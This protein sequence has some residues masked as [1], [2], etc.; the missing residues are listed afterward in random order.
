MQQSKRY[1]KIKKIGEGAF[2]NVYKAIDL[3]SPIPNILNVPAHSPILKLVEEAQNVSCEDLR[4][5]KKYS[6]LRH[7]EDVFPQ[8]AVVNINKGGEEEEEKGPIQYIALKKIKMI[9]VYIYI[10]I[11]IYIE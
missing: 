9:K 5:N 11:D 3:I 2:G 7:P 8:E 1:K 6:P 4:E 10:Y